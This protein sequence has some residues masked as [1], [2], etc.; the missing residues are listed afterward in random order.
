MKRYYWPALPSG[1]WEYMLA[2]EM[3]NYLENGGV[4]S[5]DREYG[6]TPLMFAS[7]Y[8]ANP[9]VFKVLFDNR[10][11]VHARDDDGWTPLMWASAYSNSK[12]VIQLLID[13]GADVNARTDDG[14]TALTLAFKSNNKMTKTLINNGAKE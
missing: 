9:K 4:E 14:R 12:E 11:D 2:S 13:A 7:R 8:N 10:A 6:A 5:T 3:Q 1:T